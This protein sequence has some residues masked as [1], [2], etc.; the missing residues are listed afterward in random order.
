MN[1]HHVAIGVGRLGAS[2][3]MALLALTGCSQ[4]DEGAGTTASKGTAEAADAQCELLT[5]AELV[6][7]TGKKLEGRGTTITGSTIRAC[8]YG[9]L[10]TVGLQVAKVPADEWAKALP[11]V[12]EQFKA[13]GAMGSSDVLAQLEKAAKVIEE[14]NTLPPGKACEFFSTLVEVQGKPPQTR[15]ITAYVP[16]AD[17]PVAISAQSC[18]GDTYVSLLVGRPDITPGSEL[19]S[20]ITQ[21][22]DR[23]NPEKG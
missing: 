15:S 21:T 16:T 1:S 6:S 19:E 11:G 12:V 10:E 18:Q 23:L 3:A 14:G 4:P 13:N 8:Q 5:A 22:L 7:L 20:L 17:D 2:V 9:E